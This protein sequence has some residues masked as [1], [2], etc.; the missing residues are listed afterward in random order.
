ML[1]LGS[2]AGRELDL[3][4][5]D[6]THW[7][8]HELPDIFGAVLL[9]VVGWWFAARMHNVTRRMLHKQAR[10]DPMLRGL[11]ASVVHYGILILITIAALGQLGIQTTSILAALGAAGLAIGLALQGTLSNIAA[12]LMLVWLRPFR[13]G[14]E[15][16]TANFKG[17]VREVGLFATELHSTD[18][19]FQFV[20]NSE[21]WNKRIVNYTR[22]K[23]RMVELKFGISY[24][25]DIARAK[26]VLLAC[27][28]SDDRVEKEPAPITFV[29]ELADSAVVVCL[30]AWTATPNYRPVRRA[31]TE[32]GKLALEAAGLTIPFPQRELHVRSRGEDVLRMAA[33]E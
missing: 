2:L 32:Q 21:L 33:G 8:A 24:S 30:R 6:I 28:R 4:L 22:L 3:F 26:Q 11:I 16:E 5:D 17:W 25:D 18:G 15:I 10:I 19:V 31:L 7:A 23:T 29:E 27:A 9:M 14:D 1:S 13:V 20:P 12:G